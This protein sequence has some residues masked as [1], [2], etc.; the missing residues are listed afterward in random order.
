MNRARDENLLGPH[1]DCS[2]R[3]C[4]VTHQSDDDRLNL[5]DDFISQVWLEIFS[6]AVADE[7]CSVF[8]SEEKAQT[9]HL[10]HLAATWSLS[11][12]VAPLKREW[13]RKAAGSR[14]APVVPK[15]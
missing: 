12:V 14:L 3:R 9:R 7:H 6:C 11:S 8:V 10:L 2:F 4:F 1:R 15:Q 13:W 5:K